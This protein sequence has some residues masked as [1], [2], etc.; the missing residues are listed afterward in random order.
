[1][2]RVSGARTAAAGV[3]ILVA[4]IAAVVGFGVFGA[5]SAVPRTGPLSVDA[6]LKK[7]P[8]RFVRGRGL[9]DERGA[10]SELGGAVSGAMMGPLSPV[11]L[12]SSDGA[13]VAYNAWETL[14][15]VDPEQSFSAQGISDGDAL[16][17]P[18]L[19]VHDDQGRDFLLARGAY[20]AG[21]RHDG[22]IAFVQGVDPTF[23]AGRLYSGQVVVRRGVHGRDVPWTSEAAHYVVYAWAGDRLVFYRIGL[24]EKTELLVADGPGRIRPLA[25]GTAIAV[26]PDATRVAVLSADATDV[27][28]LDI[29]TGRELSWIDVTT[30]TPSL[31][32]VAYSGSWIGDHL[33]APASP[34]LAV[35]HIG[36]DSLTLEQVLSLDRAQ[37]PVGVQEP[38]FVDD[39]GNVIAASADVPPG[40]GSGGVSFLLK[41]DRIARSCERGDAA[42]AKEWLRQVD[43]SAAA[44]DEGGR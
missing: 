41:C 2:K 19:R 28:V 3:T 5:H 27:R 21:W 4:G 29:A 6:G 17:V 7:A 22:A 32:W 18:S 31:K 38:R 37:F 12:G 24:G 14:K 11:A 36:S 15:S 43:D 20:S 33:V 40:N 25:D 42:P 10:R 16:G 35:F 1:M 9:F 13:L 30:A 23:R 39:A 26:S 8:G 34:G 44:T